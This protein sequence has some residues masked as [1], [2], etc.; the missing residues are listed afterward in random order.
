M[1][2]NAWAT[3][4][5]AFRRLQLPSSHMTLEQRRNVVEMRS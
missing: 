3:T 4:F 5:R 1:L 2:K